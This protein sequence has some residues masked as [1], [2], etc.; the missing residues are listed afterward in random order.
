VVFSLFG[1]IRNEKGPVAL[2]ETLRLVVGAC[3]DDEKRKDERP[4][5][6]KGLQDFA[7]LRVF[8]FCLL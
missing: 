1:F 6:T 7:A 5:G 4:K 2:T 3:S 8:V